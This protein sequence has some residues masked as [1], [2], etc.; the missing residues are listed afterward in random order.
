MF[1]SLRVHG[2][3]IHALM[4]ATDLLRKRGLSEAN[5]VVPPACE[6]AWYEGIITIH[7]RWSMMW[8]SL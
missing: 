6:I 7:K 1:F 8:S 4:A 5:P 3:T 2:E